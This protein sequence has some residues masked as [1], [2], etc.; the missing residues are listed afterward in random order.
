MNDG[1]LMLKL[2]ELPTPEP[3]EGVREKALH[4]AMIALSNPAAPEPA[5]GGAHPWFRLALRGF[6]CVAAAAL[7]ALLFTHTRHADV[8][9]ADAKLL[10]EMEALFP[11]QIDSVVTRGGQVDLNLAQAPDENSSQ[12][13]AVVLRR[14]SQTIRVLTFSGRKVCL[15]LGGHKECFETLVTGEGQVILTG[16]HFLWSA[17][18]PKAV[19][20]FDVQAASL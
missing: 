16:D 14:D 5:T 7:A 1:E 20:G 3:G 6:A 10:K 15:D 12:P 2:R 8:A 11:G 19:D 13:L 18:N 4:R 17:E 9:Q